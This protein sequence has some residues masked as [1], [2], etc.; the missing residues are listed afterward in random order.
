[1][2]RQQTITIPIP[3]VPSPIPKLAYTVEEAAECLSISRSLLYVLIKDGEIK[4]R[5]A[6]GRTIIAHQALLDFLAVS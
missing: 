4:T 3:E 6:G 5:K 2:K 1:M